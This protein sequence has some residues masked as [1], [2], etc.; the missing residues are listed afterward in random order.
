MYRVSKGLDKNNF[1]KTNQ[2]TRVIVGD[3]CVDIFGDSER[4]LIDENEDRFVFFDGFIF[5]VKKE[6]WIEYFLGNFQKKELEKVN[7]TFN[8]FIID[9]KSGELYTINDKYGI[10]PLFYFQNGDCVVYSPLVEALLHNSKKYEID[11]SSWADFFVFTYI[12]GDKT[13]F[14]EIKKIKPA[15]LISHKEGSCKEIK[16]WD[17]SE[18]EVSS[19]RYN[20]DEI[21][22]ESEKILKKVVEDILISI[23]DEKGKLVVNLSGG[24]D[25]RLVLSSIVRYGG[26][27]PRTFTSEKYPSD[28][29][30]VK[31]AKIVAEK[32]DCE[33]TG[34][35][36]GQNIYQRFMHDKYDSTNYSVKEHIWSMPLINF[37]R[38]RYINLDGFLGD[39]VLGHTYNYY[40]DEKTLFNIVGFLDPF[41]HQK[42]FD[43]KLFNMKELS[44]KDFSSEYLRYTKYKNP[45]FHFMYNN[46]VL[47][48]IS[49]YLSLMETRVDIVPFF[50]HDEFLKFCLSISDIKKI[51]HVIYDK[52]L[53]HNFGEIAEIE[54]SNEKKM[55][56]LYKIRKLLIKFKIMG[57][58]GQLLRRKYW[59]KYKQEDVDY[60]VERVQNQDIPE[61][62][63]ED[64]IKKIIKKTTKDVSYAY[65]LEQILVFLWW[66]NKYINFV[67]S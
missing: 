51:D 23:R 53:E 18:W 66:Y 50:C 55:K 12:L 7:G 46:R 65:Y 67:E 25:S 39:G 58:V 61:F 21:L 13:Y 47:N 22:K 32:L 38:T 59:F 17:F 9:K 29:E 20:D 63:N 33:H 37:Y 30:D 48:C 64:L 26:I 45:N 52:I 49:Y 56:F 8:C 4:Y 14:K 43:K 31:K 41:T 11:W 5:G 57:Y 60:L 24:H 35:N 54:I 36:L 3:Y 15:S 28:E 1:L 62:V 2:T 10:K 44:K 6:N 34:V 19:N 42:I 40:V 27:K 16:Y